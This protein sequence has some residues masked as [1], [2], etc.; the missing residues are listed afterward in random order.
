MTDRSNDDDDDGADAPVTPE[1]LQE[2]R[3]TFREMVEEGVLVPTGEY[4]PDRKGV[5]QPVYTLATF[6][7]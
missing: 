3:A 6:I 1:R 4:R 7:N 5:L 2:F